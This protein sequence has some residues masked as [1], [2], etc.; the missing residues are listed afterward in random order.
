MLSRQ[1]SGV[2]GR[3]VRVVG[4]MVGKGRGNGVY[5][6][7]KAV[8]VVLEAVEGRTNTLHNFPRSKRARD[9]LC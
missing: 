2:S 6:S 1:V 9:L 3:L 8:K 7:S 5:W 4:T